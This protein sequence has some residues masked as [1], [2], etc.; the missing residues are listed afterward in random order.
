MCKKQHIRKK[1][2]KYKTNKCSIGRTKSG[3]WKH[4]TRFYSF[5]QDEN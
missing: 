2:K 1:L 3:K 4:L 5:A